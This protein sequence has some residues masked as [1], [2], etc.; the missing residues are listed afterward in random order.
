MAT[1]SDPQTFVNTGADPALQALYPTTTQSIP[2]SA[3]TA[4]VYIT[5]TSQVNYTTVKTTNV[6]NQA[7]GNANTVQ[8]KTASGTFAGDDGFVYN[9]DTDT[10][11]T[12]K[13]VVTSNATSNSIL[14]GSAVFSGGIGIDGNIVA[15]RT[16]YVGFA[17]N[18][19]VLQNPTIIAKST[20]TTYVQGA[21]INV[22]EN[23]SADWVAYADN[24][25]D[26]KGWTDMGMTGSDFNDPAYTITGINDG[27]V[28]VQSTEIEGAGG[29]LVLATGNLGEVKDIVFATG[30]FQLENE[31]ARFSYA[32]AMLEMVNAGI[33]YVGASPAP[34]IT[35]F[36]SVQV[37]SYVKTVPVIANNL[38]TASAVGA[39]ARAFVTDAT[40]VT[41][42][43]VLTGGA[44]NAVPVFSD[45]TVWRIG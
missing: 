19:A 13:L 33:A 39:G 37:A 38:P 9:P 2:A 32:N 28:F 15:N 23:G 17:A 22:N 10:I 35:G 34:S 12:G 25:D 8:F 26:T 4:N 31:V 7:G 16:L 45:G 3:S 42:N 41:F 44:S 1:K 36:S 14:T 43:A 20:G 11:T 29:N 24:S 27:Y 21:L 18:A 30:G 6:V 40:S 5:Q